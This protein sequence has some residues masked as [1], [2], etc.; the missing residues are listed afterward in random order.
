MRTLEKSEKVDKEG[1]GT[2][3]ESPASSEENRE[4]GVLEAKRRKCF[5]EKDQSC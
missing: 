3:K 4:C 5:K 2:K 1:E